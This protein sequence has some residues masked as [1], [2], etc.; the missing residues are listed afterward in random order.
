MSN[1]EITISFDLLC[2]TI[3]GVK[4]RTHISEEFYKLIAS[5]L[6]SD[7]RY[8]VSPPGFFDAPD[9]IRV[10]HILW[11]YADFEV[12]YERQ[13][14]VMRDSAATRATYHAEDIIKD[15]I[16]KALRAHKFFAAA[17]PAPFLKL[18]LE[19]KMQQLIL[20]PPINLYIDLTLAWQAYEH[21][22]QIARESVRG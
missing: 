9:Y 12:S 7:P 3:L 22:L 20:P 19:R 11:R 17:D 4:D 16:V 13:L 8:R 10:N 18:I 21:E 15:C 14:K 1:R 2:D 6:A 5:H